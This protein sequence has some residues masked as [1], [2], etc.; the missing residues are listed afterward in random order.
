MGERKLIFYISKNVP[1]IHK[2]GDFDSKTKRFYNFQ[3]KKK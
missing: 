3:F 1:V 2:Q